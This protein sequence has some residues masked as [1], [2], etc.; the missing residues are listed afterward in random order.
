MM[1]RDLI[2]E[3]PSVLPTI[4]CMKL[5]SYIRGDMDVDFDDMN[6]FPFG[7]EDHHLKMAKK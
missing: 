6:E 5:A 4:A 7:L 3:L 1:Q 2:P